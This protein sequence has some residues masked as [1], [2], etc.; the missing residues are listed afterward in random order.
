[1]SEYPY[2]QIAVIDGFLR[3]TVDTVVIAQDEEGNH[4]EYFTHVREE[5]EK[6][7]LECTSLYDWVSCGD[8][9]GTGV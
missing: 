6:N 5:D 8:L 2:E 9:D 4:V 3:E 7:A 1:M